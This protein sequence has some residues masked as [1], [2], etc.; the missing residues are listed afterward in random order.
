MKSRG[1]T[2][3]KALE[4]RETAV[5]DSVGAGLLGGWP[6]SAVRGSLTQ[7]AIGRA[8][9]HVGRRIFW[10]TGQVQNASKGKGGHGRSDRW[11]GVLGSEVPERGHRESVEYAWAQ[12]AEF[13]SKH[14]RDYAVVG[15]W[16]A[17]MGV[18]GPSRRCGAP[19]TWSGVAAPMWALA[20]PGN[21]HDKGE[22]KRRRRGKGAGGGTRLKS[23]GHGSEWVKRKVVL[24]AR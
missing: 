16:R 10:A 6:A 3:D 9:G 5:M 22:V 4:T 15:R 14:W 21:G 7:H 18:V 19:L 13:R 12:S 23:A 11:E 24:C 17:M 8:M 20:F 1:N 2:V